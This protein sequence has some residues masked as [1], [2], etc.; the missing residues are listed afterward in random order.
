M[1]LPHLGWIPA[2]TLVGFLAAFV[3]G[4]LM[5]L[6]VDVYYL[7]YFAAVLGFA[8]F[9]ARATRLHVGLWV[10][11]RL[12]SAVVLGLVGGLILMQ[13]VLAQPETPKLTG[14]AFWWAV[15]WRGV[16][17]G[18]VDGLLLLALPWIVTWRAFDLEGRGLGRKIAAAMFAWI[19]VLLVT[20]TYHLGYRDFRSAKILQPNIGST[21]G[22][23]PTLMAANPVASVVSHVVL[24][25]AAVIHSPG[26]DLYLP[27]HRE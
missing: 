8:A 6:P 19:A 26:S 22:I 13:G 9:Y 7:L 12:P 16:A 1:C 21:I 27:P 17:Y 24:H 5:T 20:T 11:R 3:F 23:L 4:D 15:V 10:R 14:A 2:A 18:A 25:V